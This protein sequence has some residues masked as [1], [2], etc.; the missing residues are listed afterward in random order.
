MNKAK[1]YNFQF[2]NLLFKDNKTLFNFDLIF[3]AVWSI[4]ALLFI[5]FIGHDLTAIQAIVILTFP[6]FY[7]LCL[8]LNS[9]NYRLEAVILCCVYTT[10]FIIYMIAVT[11]VLCNFH[12]FFLSIGFSVLIYIEKE[13]IYRSYIF[14]ILLFLFLLYQIVIIRTT[15]EEMLLYQSFIMVF[16]TFFAGLVIG[17]KGLTYIYKYNATKTKLSSNEKTYQT[18]FENSSVG[19]ALIDTLTKEAPL[20]VNTKVAQ[21][22]GIKKEKIEGEK[23]YY[24]FIKDLDQSKEYSSDKLDKIIEDYHIDRLPTMFNWRLIKGEGTFIDCNVSFTPLYDNDRFLTL[25]QIIDMTELNKYKKIKQKD[26]H[27]YKAIFENAF[28]GIVYSSS[29]KNTPAYCNQKFLQLFEINEEEFNNGNI[30]NYFPEYQPDGISSTEK[31]KH[32]SNRFKLNKYHL[33]FNWLF[34]SKTGKE[35]YAEVTLNKTEEGDFVSVIKNKNQELEAKNSLNETKHLYNTL[36]KNSIDGIEIYKS[37]LNTGKILEYRI[38]EPF[39]NLLLYETKELKNLSNLEISPEYQ[40]NGIS[41]AD[42]LNTIGKKFRRD[43]RV[44]Y[45]WN[46]IK[47]NGELVTV[48]ISSVREVKDN[49]VSVFSI[50]KDLTNFKKTENALVRSERLYRTLF[51]SIY[52]G[53]EIFVEN[54]NTGEKISQ[55]TNQKLQDLFKLKVDSKKSFSFTN[56]FPEK[57]R[58]GRLSLVCYDETQKELNENLYIN[59]EWS[60]VNEDNELFI[61]NIFIA[62]FY[63]NDTINTVT[64]LKDITEQV[65]Q[66]KVIKKQLNELN[67]KNNQLE[68]YINSNLQLENFAYMASHDLKAPIRSIVGFSQI[69]SKSATNKLDENEKEYLNFIITSSNNMQLLIEDL[70]NYARVNNSEKKISRVSIPNT[71]KAVTLEMNS[72]IKEKSAKISV[73]TVPDL[74]F[75]DEIKL[76]MLFQNLIAN[77]I[78]FHKKD[79]SPTIEIAAIEQEDYWEFSIKDNGIGINSEYLDKI[80]LLFRKLHSS[81][82]YQG[83]GIGLAT[84]K[85]IAELHQGE[86]WV[87]SIPNTGS[88]FYFTISKNLQ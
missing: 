8:V 81:Q 32:I 29:N 82:E 59:K 38:N 15:N 4:I 78:K 84:C 7:G 71:L 40:P 18:L 61:C 10:F 14:I 35:I 42:Y 27:R 73:N 48:E 64:I 87:E 70:L 16:N 58:D 22:L 25:V 80:F 83:T 19:V 17:I 49:I 43:N 36:F 46:L 28:D 60:F 2:K 33:R 50:F 6:I 34:V 77:G 12:M 86:I 3:T 79:I 39:K 52:D 57:Q 31:Y 44:K 62:K 37:D 76:R 26:D 53:I 85:K 21:L 75:A 69:L 65:N 5:M 47:K 67:K 74:I 23:F 66:E 63:D 24:M 11:S 51:S 54:S 41:S 20:Q 45:E 1:N 68:K 56:Y 88:T 30:K 13:T 9:N 55:F 72:I